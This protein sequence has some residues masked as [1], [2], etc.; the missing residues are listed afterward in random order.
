MITT[1]AFIGGFALGGIFGM[2]LTAVIVAGE[3][4]DRP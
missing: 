4:D 1:L 3:P 2:I